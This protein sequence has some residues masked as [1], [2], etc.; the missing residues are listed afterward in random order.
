[1][2]KLFFLLTVLLLVPLFVA[3]S[4]EARDYRFN[5][6]T[7]PLAALGGPIYVTIVPVTGEY[8]LLFEARTAEHQSIEAGLSYL[9]PSL[10]LNMDE[11]SEGDSLEGVRTSGFRVQVAYKFFL[12][13][14]TKAPEGFYVGPHF[15]YARATVEARD[16][17]GDSFIASKTNLNLIFG[18]QLI[19]NGGFVL[20][21]YAGLGV[22]I[23]DYQFRDD[24]IFDFD[25]GNDVVPNV[26]LG[27]TFGF[28]F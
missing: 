1:M 18:Y 15:S 8:K 20:N 22:K 28:A 7:N 3:Q 2:K 19:S 27:F 12:T 10:L 16:R 11:L 26:A 6:K 17:E 24:T 25:P 14:D 13:R 21:I 5:F 23:R 9:G 4:Q